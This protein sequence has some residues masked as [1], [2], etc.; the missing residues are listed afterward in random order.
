MSTRGPLIYVISISSPKLHLC[1]T[2][3]TQNRF[4]YQKILTFC[5]S[6]QYT[7]GAHGM[8]LC[9][10]LNNPVLFGGKC[11]G[12]GGTYFRLLGAYS[13]L[14]IVPIHVGPRWV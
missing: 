8:G 2:T 14:Q 7:I 9:H 10:F 5:S 3:G 6:V 12:G 11:G 13:I 4:L 1:L